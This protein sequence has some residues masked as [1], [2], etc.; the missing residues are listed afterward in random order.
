M[1]LVG[2]AIRICRFSS[3]ILILNIAGAIIARFAPEDALLRWRVMEE[4]V[5][6]VGKS[7]SFAARRC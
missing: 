2:D 1:N 3:K 6:G 5:T 7:I 4:V